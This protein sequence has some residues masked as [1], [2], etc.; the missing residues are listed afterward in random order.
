MILGD[1]APFPQGGLLFVINR[2]S[3]GSTNYSLEHYR[4]WLFFYKNPNIFCPCIRLQLL[5]CLM[6]RKTRILAK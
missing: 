1:G 5:L 4:F 6:L 2:K 3:I